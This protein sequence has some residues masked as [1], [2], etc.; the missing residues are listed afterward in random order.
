VIGGIAFRNQG[1]RFRRSFL[2][3]GLIREM[4]SR[5]GLTGL[6]NRRA[7]DE[8]LERAWQQALRDRRRLAI[9]LIDL[10]LFKS[11][12]DRYGHQAGD[13]ALL[14]I[15]RV[16]GGFAQRPLDLAAR[17]GGEELALILFDVSREHASKIAEHLRVAVANLGLEHLD[18]KPA[19]VVTVS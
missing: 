19:Q 10:D 14:R 15:A 9:L 17:Y 16:V 8:H 18:R 2:E 3:R 1:I 11:F 12:N 4:A 7:F 6:R 13:E 5:D